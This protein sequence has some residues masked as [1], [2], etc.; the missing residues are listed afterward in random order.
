[1]RT[2]LAPISAA[3]L[4]AALS[5]FAPA[6][7]AQWAPP[8]PLAPSEV[9]EPVRV[10]A[11]L[12]VRPAPAPSHP[13]PDLLT[14]PTSLPG[15]LVTLQWGV[16][17][18]TSSLGTSFGSNTG[19]A[20]SFDLNAGLGRHFELDAGASLRFNG[21]LAA[22]RMGR[23]GRDDVFQ[24]GNR[25]IGNP[26]VSLRWS[27]ADGDD[28]AFNMGVEALWQV[29]IA[30]ATTWS[31]GVGLPIRFV[32]PRAKLRIET[33]VTAQFVLSDAA[34]IRDVLAVPVRIYWVPASIFALGVVTGVQF[35]NVFNGVAADPHMPFGIIA[36]WRALPALEIGVQWTLPTAMPYGT[37]AQGF[38]ISLTHRAR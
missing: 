33:G 12:E 28:R 16:G 27:F 4:A 10:Y 32:L 26:W 30:Q 9:P 7:H 37:D 20:L 1:M 17:V 2:S 24:T 15:G 8:P 29:P 21:L 11:P 3:A 35:P 23:V 36:R 38:G 31:V 13:L 14:R 5:G 22:D 18:A 25:S 6:A 19:G 34:D